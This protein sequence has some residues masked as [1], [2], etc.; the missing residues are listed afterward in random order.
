MKKNQY[1]FQ[2][3]QP[4]ETLSEKEAQQNSINFSHP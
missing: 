2:C 1:Y 3:S 4:I